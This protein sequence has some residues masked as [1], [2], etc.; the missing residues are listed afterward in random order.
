MKSRPGRKLKRH[1][2]PCH[3]FDDVRISSHCISPL[4]DVVLSM[5]TTLAYKILRVLSLFGIDKRVEPDATKHLL[6]S[7]QGLTTVLEIVRLGLQDNEMGYGAYTLLD[8]DVNV[9]LRL[10]GLA[11]VIIRFGER[12]ETFQVLDVCAHELDWSLES[13]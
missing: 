11:W 9:V 6:N 5:I 12:I 13:V 8:A 7:C 3:E 2:K 4:Q 10:L 1:G